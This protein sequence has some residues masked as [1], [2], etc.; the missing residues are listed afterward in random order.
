VSGTIGDGTGKVNGLMLDVGSGGSVVM[1]TATSGTASFVS[2]AP[3]AACPGFTPTA[4]VTCA[5]ETMTVH[6]TMTAGTRNASH[7]SDAEAP[8]MRLF[9]TPP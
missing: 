7:P 1:Y 4:I 2:G 8:G 3:G 9:Y 6:F 5:L